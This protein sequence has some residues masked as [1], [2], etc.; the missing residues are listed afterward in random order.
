MAARDFGTIGFTFSGN[1]ARARELAGF[2]RTLMGKQ[3]EYMAQGALPSDIRTIPLVDGSIIRLVNSANLKRIFIWSPEGD[4][5]EYPQLGAIVATPRSTEWAG[6]GFDWGINTP[7]GEENGQ[8]RRVLYR[9]GKAIKSDVWFPVWS[10]DDRWIRGDYPNSAWDVN[11][12]AGNMD[13]RSA[14]G[15]TI[16]SWGVDYR[17]PTDHSTTNRYRNSSTR[18]ERMIYSEGFPLTEARNSYDVIGAGICAATNQLICVV[19][20]YDGGL[21]EEWFGVY[22]RNYVPDDIWNKDVYHA[23]TAPN[24]WRYITSFTVEN[25]TSRGN[26]SPAIFNESGTEFSFIYWGLDGAGTDPEDHFWTYEIDSSGSGSFTLKTDETIDWDI[27][28]TPSV[29]LRERTAYADA[30]SS[31]GIVCS[32]TVSG[33]KEGTENNRSV[34]VEHSVFRPDETRSKL[35]FFDYIGDTLEKVYLKERR[36]EDYLL[37]MDRATKN[38]DTYY[39]CAGSGSTCISCCNIKQ[40]KGGSYDE[41]TTNTCLGETWFTMNGVKYYLAQSVNEIERTIHR[42]QDGHSGFTDHQTRGNNYDDLNIL[43]LDIRVGFIHYT[44]TTGDVEEIYRDWGGTIQWRSG[45]KVEQHEIMTSGIGAAYSYTETLSET[46]QSGSIPP[47]SG[48]ANSITYPWKPNFLC[49]YDMTVCNYLGCPS[50]CG[51]AVS[52][53]NSFY[54]DEY[55][56]RDNEMRTELG[57]KWF[58]KGENEKY[59]WLLNGKI[60]VDAGL[61]NYHYEYSEADLAEI[62]PIYDTNLRY[63]IQGVI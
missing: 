12:K 6:W 49:L 43:G 30:D 61:G 46:S 47:S 36:K 20:D 55:E 14:D 44:Q 3:N 1:E 51:N 4:D 53:G 50:S 19:S 62:N 56:L 9:E 15:K 37:S 34:S 26:M 35:L 63:N 17:E 48:A 45:K 11:L 29:S 54:S 58:Q 16:L 10:I 13:W 18:F 27:S 23:T 8:Y 24:G 5:E 31:L 32:G 39:C 2:A 21:D 22:M 60:A 57:W 59:E 40:Y 41:V 38:W 7:Y 28:W 25:Q 52:S 33:D 42:D